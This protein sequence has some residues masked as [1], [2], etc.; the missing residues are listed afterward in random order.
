MDKNSIKKYVLMLFFSLISAFLELIG[1]TLLLYTILAI[2]EP[3]FIGKFQFT[4]YLYHALKIESLE[5]F[6]LFLTDCFIC[7]S[8]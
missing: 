3:N 1:V 4:N 7:Y 8:Q 6:I 2:F 5:L